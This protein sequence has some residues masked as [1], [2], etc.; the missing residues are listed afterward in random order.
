M[1]WV[2]KTDFVQIICFCFYKT[3]KLNRI[4]AKN[5]W[6]LTKIEGEIWLY[7]I[8][9]IMSSI[10]LMKQSINLI[11]K[12]IKSIISERNYLFI[13]FNY[14]VRYVKSSFSLQKV[15]NLS[16]RYLKF[17]SELICFCWYKREQIFYCLVHLTSARWQKHAVKC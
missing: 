3:P 5:K 9:K 12:W 6:I 14:V 7:E 15:L 8:Y 4:N 16:L 13:C 10:F 1:S 2:L 17:R 11:I